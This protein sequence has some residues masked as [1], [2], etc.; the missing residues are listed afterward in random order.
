MVN[1]GTMIASLLTAII[2]TREVV[3]VR[4][5]PKWKKQV[6]FQNSIIVLKRIVCVS[7]YFPTNFD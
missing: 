3:A 5:V 4:Y 1:H 7:S 2:V 6:N